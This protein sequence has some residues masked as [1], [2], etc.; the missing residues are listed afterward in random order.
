MTLLDLFT[1]FF[2]EI[3]GENGGIFM[4]VAVPRGDLW[5]GGGW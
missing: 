4:D 3:G 2:G 1:L 5:P